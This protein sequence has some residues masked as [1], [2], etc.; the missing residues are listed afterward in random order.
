MR[1]RIHPLFFLFFVLVVFSGHARLFC[2]TALSLL[3]HELGHYAS[4]RRRGY[5]AD[6]AVLTPFG[7]CVSFPEE[8]D[9]ISERVVALSGPAVSLALSAAALS[10]CLFLPSETALLAARVNLM[11]FLFNLLPAYPLDGSRVVLSCAKNR[12]R[13]LGMLRVS[14]MLIGACFLLA[15]ILCFY[16]GGVFNPT[17]ALFSLFM[18]CGAVTGV[19]NAYYK[20]VKKVFDKRLSLP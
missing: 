12:F 17:L 16:I 11:L 15:F 19:E 14:G 18:F 20:E 7:L 6:S 13:A 4:A 1:L 5:V 2:V 9:K 3:L 10:V 8:F